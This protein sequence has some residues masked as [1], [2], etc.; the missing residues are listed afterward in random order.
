MTTTSTILREVEGTGSY[1]MTINVNKIGDYKAVID[2]IVSNNVLPT[3]LMYKLQ[4]NSNFKSKFN[5]T[6][7]NEPIFE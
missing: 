6:D 5:E 3:I 2:H 7:Y 4:N 1:L